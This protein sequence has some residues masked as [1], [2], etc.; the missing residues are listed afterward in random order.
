MTR[1]R[2]A[3]L[4]LLVFAALL[5]L[6]QGQ[7]ISSDDFPVPA[8]SSQSADDVAALN[9]FPY[10]ACTDY[11]CGSSPYQLATPSVT[12]SAS[13]TRLCYTFRTVPPLASPPACY[14]KLANSFVKIQFEV[15][16]SCRAAMVNVT[17]NNAAKTWLWDDQFATGSMRVT[18]LRL[19]S[20]NATGQVLCLTLRNAV[21]ASNGVS[22]LVDGSTLWRL[23]FV[24]AEAVNDRI[25]YI[26]SLAVNPTVT[27][28]PLS[29][30][31]G[32]CVNQTLDAISFNLDPAYRDAILDVVTYTNLGR[33]LPNTRAVL[34]EYGVKVT[35]LGVLFVDSMPLG[36]FYTVEVQV[37]ASVWRDTT[38][39]PCLPSLYEPGVPACDYQLHGW[40]T[41]PGNHRLQ[42]EDST[43]YRYPACCPEG[44]VQFCKQQINSQC[45]PRLSDTPYRLQYVDT[46]TTGTRTTV[47]FR[48]TSVAVGAQL[49]TPACDGSDLAEIKLY[50]N[51]SAASALTGAT[52]NG[53]AISPSSGSDPEQYI[54]LPVNVAAG[55]VDSPLSLTFTGLRGHWGEHAAPPG[56]VQLGDLEAL[57]PVGKEYQQ[58]YKL[59]N[60][61]LPKGT[62]P[63]LGVMVC[64]ETQQAPSVL[65]AC[66]AVTGAVRQN[67]LILAIP[68]LLLT[69]ML[70]VGL[71]GVLFG[72]KR[73]AQVSRYVFTGVHLQTPG[74]LLEGADGQCS[75][76]CRL[77]AESRL[78]VVASSLSLAFTQ[79]SLPVKQAVDLIS[80]I[81][82]YPT[83]SHMWGQWVPPW[84]SWVSSQRSPCTLHG[85]GRLEA[86]AGAPGAQS[87]VLFMVPHG[88]VS[89]V[90]PVNTNTVTQLGVDILQGAYRAQTLTNLAAKQINVAAGLEGSLA[91]AAAVHL[92][93]GPYSA[94]GFDIRFVT[95]SIQIYFSNVSSNES[96]GIP[97]QP[98]DCPPE[99]CYNPAT[100]TRWWCCLPPFAAPHALGCI[101][102]AIARHTPCS[103]GCNEA[104]LVH[105]CRWGSAGITLNVDACLAD[106]SGQSVLQQFSELGLQHRLTSPFFGDSTASYTV[107][108]ST[109]AAMGASHMC[110]P[111][112]LLDD[113]W[114][115]CVWSDNWTPAYV[116][117]LMVVIVLVALLL[118]VTTFTVLLSRH[119]HKTLLHSLLPKEAIKQLHARF[120]WSA[121]VDDDSVAQAMV[122]SG[123]WSEVHVTHCASI[124][125]HGAAGTPAEV[126]LGIMEDN[127][128]GRVPALPKV[129]LVKTTLQ[130]SLDVYKPL[131]SA[132][133]ERMRQNVDMDVVEG[134]TMY[135]SCRAT[136]NRTSRLSIALVPL[137]PLQSNSD[138]VY[139]QH[140]L[141]LRFPDNG[142]VV[143]L[144]QPC[145][146]SA[147][148][149]ISC[150]EVTFPAARRT[151][152]DLAK[153]VQHS[154]PRAHASTVPKSRLSQVATSSRLRVSEAGSLE[155][156]TSAPLLNLTFDETE[157]AAQALSSVLMRMMG[158]TQKEPPPPGSGAALLAG[159]APSSF[160]GH[161]CEL[162]RDS[163]GS[164]WRREGSQEQAIS[165]PQALLVKKPAPGLP[166]LLLASAST[167]TQPR[168][169]RMEA[170]C[171]THTSPQLAAYCSP[172]T[173][174]HC[175][176]EERLSSDMELPVQLPSMTQVE[177]S[178]G[179]AEGWAFDAFRLASVTGGRP[180]SVLAYWLLHRAGLIEWACLD[181]SKLARWLC[182]IEDGYCSNA[183]HNRT[184]AADV[185]QT[186]GM[187]TTHGLGPGYV[188]SLS[189]L[190]AYLAAVC[191]DYQHIGR[192][193][194]W[195]VETEDEL[196]LRYN[197]RS[198]MENHH[199]AG[200]FN[201]LKHPDLN[202]IATM[203]KVPP[204]GS[205]QCGSVPTLCLQANRQR[206]RKLMVEL[207]LSTDMKQH[208]AIIGSFTALHRAGG[209]G[210]ASHSATVKS[211]FSKQLSALRHGDQLSSSGS[212]IGHQGC[213]HSSV[214][215]KQGQA[216][217]Q[218]ELQPVSDQDKLLSLQARQAALQDKLLCLT[219]PHKQTHHQ[220]SWSCLQM[221]LK[222][223]DLGHLAAPLPVHL[224][225]V[226]Q[227]EAEFFA[228]GDAERAQGLTISPL[229]DRT[230]QGIT[231]SQIGFFDFVALP[232]FNNFTS[233]FI[234][235]KPL[236]RGVLRNYSYWQTEA[237]TPLR[238]CEKV[239]VC[240]RTG[241]GKSTLMITLYRLVEP[242]GGAI[243]I[244]GVDV[245]AIG[246][247]DLRSRLSLVPQDPV[248]FS[249]TLRSNLDPFA[250]ASGDA[251]IW[252]AVRRASLT[253]FVRGLDG[254]LDAVIKEGGANLSVGQRQLL[255][256]AR[257]LLRASRILVL[258]GDSKARLYECW[259]AQDEAT[260]NVD[261]ATD[262][263]IQATI[264]SA[265]ADCTV[266]TIA[267][268]LHTIIDPDRILLLNAGKL[269]EFESPTVLLQGLASVGAWLLAQS[270]DYELS[271]VSEPGGNKRVRSMR[272]K[273]RGRAVATSSS[274]RAQSS[275]T[276]LRSMHAIAEMRAVAPA[277]SSP[278]QPV[279]EQSTK[280]LIRR[281][282]VADVTTA[283]HGSV[284][285]PAALTPPTSLGWSS[286][287]HALYNICQPT[288]LLGAGEYGKVGPTPHGHH[289]LLAE[290]RVTGQQVAV[291]MIAKQRD[292]RTVAQHLQCIQAE[293][294]AWSSCQGSQYVVRLEGLYEDAEHVM[295]VQELCSGG[296]LRSVLKR[297]QL[298]EFETAQ[299][300]RAV[301]DVV[302]ECHS[303][304]ILYGDFLCPSSQILFDQI[305]RLPPAPAL[306]LRPACVVLPLAPHPVPFL[307]LPIQAKVLAVLSQVKPANFLLRQPHKAVS[308]LRFPDMPPATSPTP[309][310]EASSHLDGQPA[311]EEGAAAA[312][313]QPSSPAAP[314]YPNNTAYSGSVAGG[315]SSLAQ[316]VSGALP[317]SLPTSGASPQCGPT[318]PA[319][320]IVLATDFGCA[321]KLHSRS[322]CSAT[323][324]KRMGSPVFMAPEQWQG[325]SLGLAS[326]IW[327]AGVMMYQLLSGRFPF[328]ADV[329]AE[330]VDG[331]G[332]GLALYKVVCAIQSNP[333]LL[334]G[335]PWDR[336]SRPC[337][338]LLCAMLDRQPSTRISAH[339]A[340][341]HS[342]FR[343]QL[344]QVPAV[345]SPPLQPEQSGTYDPDDYSVSSYSHQHNT[346]AGQCSSV[347]EWLCRGK[348]V[349]GLM[350]C[351]EVPPS[352][353][354]PPQDP[355]PPP[356]PY[357]PPTPAQA[358]PAQ[359]QPPPAAPG[360]VQ[361]PQAP[362]WGR[363]LDR[364][365]NGCLY[366]Q[367]IGKSVQRPLELCSYEGL[368]ALPPVGDQYQQRYKLVNDRLPKVR[369]R[370][371]RAAEY[372]R[373]IDDRARN[374]A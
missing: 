88:V 114:E 323:A 100:R 314:F 64:H 106:S 362:P 152:P 8:E 311:A 370:L 36:D 90:Y 81:R 166:L 283:H 229:C 187:L 199:L 304:G 365:T 115:L 53:N 104:V 321:Q 149:P 309:L 353:P 84:W 373:G 178:L 139:L 179:T 194:D 286:R 76:V 189:M 96:F 239:G 301:L 171:K 154:Q 7:E 175:L 215:S 259:W 206:L 371:H 356:A 256:M 129:M 196:A 270:L 41:A 281:E 52:F 43:G 33:V 86:A 161:W 261:N 344:G 276:C 127:L 174:V 120:D 303:Q 258:V 103:F 219:E 265:F 244:D 253:D 85:A 28:H 95:L 369:Q 108:E 218:P 198:P 78:E 40:Q 268:R 299:V 143:T 223:S 92:G 300:M 237:T 49:G 273:F 126:I 22:P 63:R 302:H 98:T 210:E 310:S 305:A 277:P 29:Y 333:V 94:P 341:H 6:A 11:R 222:C 325:G 295:L 248:I 297:G 209:A 330:Q 225:W 125:M 331:Q 278:I 319:D 340:L 25:V 148:P 35:M 75:L 162:P 255:C 5:F 366:L 172:S 105:G 359:A 337:K 211:K 61:R 159:G 38:R 50:V 133:S 144:G 346:M 122:D 77:S 72:A 324:V 180:L 186:L 274:H 167:D 207:V 137:P 231:K 217:G 26:F 289:V 163:K 123:G 31:R 69:T 184:H 70:T 308:C 204:G 68:L 228:Q 151:P 348:Y 234:G 293:V 130:Q 10:C 66:K 121:D 183:Y 58:R 188:D 317:V 203:P 176:D 334:T 110:R 128:M 51:S 165:S 82:D 360:P 342:W 111:I 27:A 19:S 102:I 266:L 240:G 14:T 158:H 230:K 170:A 112:R 236:L 242:C 220:H 269:A 250:A 221:A 12:A 238:G 109:T 3:R 168:P 241:C 320:I 287:F 298:T 117:P 134:E 150:S 169:A 288:V 364:D 316:V 87:V 57:P 335:A 224:A 372:R 138:T 156:K 2:T 99:L 71:W 361:R 290:H 347:A 235:A 247:R 322:R 164:E 294:E 153:A 332:A 56:A 140:E 260:S 208:F 97:W 181:A 272:I 124:T 264:R 135:T 34:T 42:L 271:V 355:P 212:S 226:S 48:V 62:S 232:L 345:R 91:V 368:E 65:H 45:N 307:D 192:T 326:D 312:R 182:R 291:K 292:D 132:L 329:P 227:L 197:D 352:P 146:S 275:L 367:R 216:V 213:N 15:D 18:V 145:S 245:A 202:F 24:Q 23:N 73:D 80:H 46:R 282:P 136:P 177:A 267:H 141:S 306:I 142:N 296:D 30:R 358:P 74:S 257:A 214:A 336:V 252:E 44:V 83:L 233:R 185:V 131:R 89:E 147:L 32:S 201:L 263:L 1:G 193:N 249:G 339:A 315:S 67:G 47:N 113:V 93:A 357:P 39:F 363:W 254:G 280:Q 285:G 243:I 116:L 37:N 60:D 279:R 191:H 190:A 354:P 160:P 59:V 119:E 55:A 118:S 318:C 338:D 157:V 16:K 343:Q 349:R 13:T 107:S 313:A 200:A 262:N 54:L 155:S 350:L 9:S 251:A 4:L 328:W 20:A 195:L 327:A 374:N 246:L 101:I 284:T 351:H 173:A 17:L 21:T 79:A 205:E